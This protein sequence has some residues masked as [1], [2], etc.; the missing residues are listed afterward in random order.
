MT[1]ELTPFES[2]ARKIMRLAK[3]C[4][5]ER[6]GEVEARIKGLTAELTPLADEQMELRRLLKFLSSEKP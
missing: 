3:E 6:L 1:A 2:E 5:L 4:A